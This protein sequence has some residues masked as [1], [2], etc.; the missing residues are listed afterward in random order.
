MRGA[1]AFVK[2][3]GVLTCCL[4]EFCRAGMADAVT[5]DGG[6]EMGKRFHGPGGKL[7]REDA[8]ITAG[9]SVELERLRVDELAAI[10]LLYMPAC[11]CAC[12]ETEGRVFDRMP[13]WI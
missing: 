4:A 13:T 11:G 1:G 3:C 6:S 12:E 8:A 2:L 7:S 9:G 10:D 5:M